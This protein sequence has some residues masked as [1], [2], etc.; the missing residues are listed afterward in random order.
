MKE[1]ENYELYYFIRFRLNVFI[2][3]AFFSQVKQTTKS[4]Y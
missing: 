2:R 4:L 1:K 3:L